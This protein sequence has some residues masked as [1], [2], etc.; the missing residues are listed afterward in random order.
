MAQCDVL[1]QPLSATSTAAM[2]ATATSA[3]VATA[4]VTQAIVTKT[5][6]GNSAC[7]H[8]NAMM[9]TVWSPVWA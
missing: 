4:V 9:G 8:H 5:A 7:W 6:I 3:A 2:T 1:L